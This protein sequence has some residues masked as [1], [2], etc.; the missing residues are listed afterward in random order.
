MKFSI[1]T[2]S[3]NQLPYLKRC[4]ASVRDQAVSTGA[5]KSE[6]LSR[7]S[8]RPSD[9]RP[10]TPGLRIHHHIQDGGSTDGTVEFLREYI[11]RQPLTD[12][13]Q[14]TF[15]SQADEGMYDA[16]NKGVTF[17]F[18]KQGDEGLSDNRQLT[19]GNCGDE[20]VAWLNC[21]EQYLPGTLSFARD[22]F[23]AHPEADML[24]GSALLIRP[25]GELLAF[26]KAY[27]LRR[28]YIAASHLYNLSCGM[29]FRRRVF[30]Q[31]IRF[32]VSY[33]NLGDQDWVMRLLQNGI[34]AGCTGRF[35]SAFCFTGQNMSRTEK[36]RSEERDL[37]SRYPVW[38]RL[39]CG[40]LNLLR[41]S[42]KALHRAY[43]QRPFDYAVYPDGNTDRRKTFYAER[44]SFRWPET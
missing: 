21:D 38:V 35:L 26:R 34:R 11:S 36:A 30:D 41:W 17:T 29:F 43:F 37:R 4:V 33:R 28:C 27:P 25:D 5:K 20:I 31:G 15:A 24:S 9:F 2:P 39:L 32:D 7:K 1:I 12:N 44:A 18:Q 10:L 42:E 6:I 8:N 23:A 14:L 22:W 40:P 19:T 13:Y 3:F 16:L